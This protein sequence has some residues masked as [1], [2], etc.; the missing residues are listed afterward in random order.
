MRIAVI[1][2]DYPPSAR[3][4]GISHFVQILATRLTRLGEEVMVLTDDSYRGDGKDGAVEVITL[5]GLW[6][7]RTTREI[8]GLLKEKAIELVNLQYAPTLYST[9][10]KLSWR[11]VAA[12][13]PSVISFHTL[14]GGSKVNYLVALCLLTTRSSLVAT[15]SEIVYL[16]D[17]RLPFFGR[18]TVTI[19]IGSNIPPS[20]RLTDTGAL[21]KKYE[22]TVNV[23]IVSYFGM[24]YPGKGM[25]TLLS[26]AN[27][28]ASRYGLDFRLVLI[29]GGGSDVDYYHRE[30]Q[31]L[32]D[33][34]GVSDRVVWTGKI[35]AGEVSTLLSMT[36]V[37]LLPYEAGVS[38]RRGSL[39]AALAH[40]RAIVTSPPRLRFAYF[41]NQE[42]MVWPKQHETEAF[43]G[44]VLRIL[45]DDA[46]RKRLEKGALRLSKCY[47]W[48][49]IAERTRDWFRETIEKH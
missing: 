40:G 45:R 4:G 14:W 2:P 12:R 10:F 26:T 1:C 31:K 27:I 24:C 42:N 19:P 29:G 8:V 43:A 7:R 5:T 49:D 38:D 20:G 47:Q 18:K 48:A 17:K 44:E 39:M 25:D 37:V 6:D 22:L 3:E 30:M 16:L 15:N 34:H 11:R 28:L 36:D 35:S 21:R 32:S 23:P 13:F 33:S 41:R 46:L 9:A